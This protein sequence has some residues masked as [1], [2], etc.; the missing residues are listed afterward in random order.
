MPTLT[1]RIEKT[2]PIEGIVLAGVLELTAESQLNGT[3][4]ATA[5]TTPRMLRTCN[6]ATDLGTDA[7]R[8]CSL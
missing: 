7:P 2:R 6:A 8:S 3:A 1:H 4:S 5:P